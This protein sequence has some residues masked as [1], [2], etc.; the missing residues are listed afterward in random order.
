VSQLL[1]QSPTD[2]SR[3]VDLDEFLFPVSNDPLI[4][5]ASIYPSGLNPVFSFEEPA[6]RPSPGTGVPTLAWI[7]VDLKPEP[8]YM[9]VSCL[10]SGV[11]VTSSVS[12]TQ[13]RIGD[14]VT[15]SFLAPPSTKRV[16]ICDKYQ[17]TDQIQQ[18]AAG[19]YTFTYT[20]R[21]TDISGP[22]S[23]AVYVPWP[24][25]ILAVYTQSTGLTIGT[26][27]TLLCFAMSIY[28]HSSHLMSVSS[29]IPYLEPEPIYDFFQTAA[30]PG[31][32]IWLAIVV[33]Y[34]YVT[35]SVVVLKDRAAVASS[36]V[37]LPFLLIEGE[38]AF[39]FTYTLVDGDL[40]RII[41][42]V[43]LVTADVPVK[44]TTYRT[45]TFVGKVH[46]CMILRV[47]SADAIECSSYAHA[48]ETPWMLLVIRMRPI[49]LFGC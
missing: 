38:S 30:V 49:H 9:G 13:L 32:V 16:K 47:C 2:G 10:V 37:N 28:R 39:N 41:W 19:R 23:V 46:F 26:P 27:N 20:V 4:I 12:G 17:P 5:S 22:C 1:G 36:Q 43:D 29:G 21:P 33:R 48:H 44:V 45:N 11:T 35:P 14:A 18:D 6:S 8:I 15:V 3:P 7:N 42:T 34:P 25:D 40:G 24:G 31:M